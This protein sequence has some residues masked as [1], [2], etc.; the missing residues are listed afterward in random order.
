VFHFQ[1]K[2]ILPAFKIADEHDKGVDLPAIQ[3]LLDE[4]A[5]RLFTVCAIFTEFPYVQYQSESVLSKTLAV[6]LHDALKK[7][8]SQ[9]KNQKVREPRGTILILDRGFDLISPVIHDYYYQSIVYETKEV[10]DEGEVSIGEKKTALLN[11]QDELWVRFRNKHVAEVHAKLN[12]EVSQVA[13]ESKKKVG[14]NTEDMSLQDMAE[15]I[16]SM[17]KYEEMMKKYQVHMELIN[18]GLTEFTK[19]NWR[20]LVALEQDVISGVDVKG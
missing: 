12:E 8:Y 2:H 11:D 14:K 7:F 5:H 18:K 1:K 17:P 9:S 6:K 19:N 15:V 4:L 10:G 13:Q 20:K 16:R 3:S